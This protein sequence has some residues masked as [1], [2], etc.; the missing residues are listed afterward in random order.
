MY[1]DTR[2]T[3]M[4]TKIKAADVVRFA[5]VPD[6]TWMPVRAQGY[7]GTVVKSTRGGFVKV[8]FDGVDYPSCVRDGCLEI[9]RSVL[10]VVSRDTTSGR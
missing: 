5:G 7:V 2:G 3:E 6:T 8:R 4:T 10:T 9:N 1:T